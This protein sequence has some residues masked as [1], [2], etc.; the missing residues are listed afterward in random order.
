MNPSF[1][2]W[3][4]F[5]L[6]LLAALGGASALRAQEAVKPPA[7]ASAVVYACPMHADAMASKPGK[8]PRCGMNLKAIP[9]PETADFRVKLETAPRAVRAGVPAKLRFTVAHPRTGEQVKDFHILHDMPFHLFVV[10]QDLSHFEHVH[11][12]LQR[13][14]S[15]TIE[16]TFPKDG[17][18]RIYCDFF[19]AGG[20]PQVAFLNLVTAGFAD[21]IVASQAHLTPDQEL[22]KSVDGINF[23]LRIDPEKF[24]AGQQATLIY[25]LAD[26]VTGEP[27]T[28]LQPYLGAWGHTLILSEDGTDYLHS[29]PTEMVPD[30]ADRAKFAGKPEVRFETFFP[31]PGNYRIWSQFQRGGRLTTVSFTVYVPRLGLPKSR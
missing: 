6:T 18:Y 28:D 24:F 20:L 5:A 27:L 25:H 9:A 21:D 13:D 12:D 17:H 8:C 31:R 23:N 26:A 1:R 30:N 2:R 14:G 7:S 15:L 19:P 4:S 29:H 16:T 10:S 11:P 22:K 3:I